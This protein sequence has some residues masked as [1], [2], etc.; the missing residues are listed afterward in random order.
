VPAVD[1]MQKRE[2]R[3]RVCGLAEG[4]M[5]QGSQSSSGDRGFQKGCGGV[6]LGGGL[7][8]GGSHTEE[9]QGVVW[10]VR[11]VKAGG[12]WRPAGVR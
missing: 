12:S 5:G 3:S 10:A 4:E 2:R 8:G 11:A 9:E 7:A 1:E 6:D